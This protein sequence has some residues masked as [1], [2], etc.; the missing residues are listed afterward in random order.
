MQI[1]V[2]G[3]GKMGSSIARKLHAK[4]HN[5]IVWNR[6]KEDV[7]N[8]QKHVKVKSKDNLQ[9]LVAHLNKPRI[10]WVML[11]H[12]ALN[13]IFD[14]LEKHLEKGDILVDGGNSFFGDTEKRFKEF[15]KNG[16]KFLGI[17]V[18][19][20]V[21]GEKNGYSLMVG[22]DRSAYEY[23]RPILKTLS[24]PSGSYDYFGSGG[25]GHFVKM[26]HN[27]IEYGMMQSIGEGFEVLK[28]SSYKLDL[29]KIAKVWQK[30]T[31]VSGFLIDRMADIFEKDQNLKNVIGELAATGEAQWTVDEA[32]KQKTPV[33][34]IESSLNYRKRSKTDRKIQNSFTAKVIA[35]LRNAFGGHGVKK[36]F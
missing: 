10:V 33:E 26:V 3:L 4:G 2:V 5:V 20:G 8:L 18:S 19:G 31:I 21:H 6:T 27:G 17:G 13:E 14:H 23:I 22:G 32:K 15:K 34:L 1:G 7:L 36:K 29:L 30:G 24:S 25:A 28:K 9:D 35:S 16:I 11:P 12:M